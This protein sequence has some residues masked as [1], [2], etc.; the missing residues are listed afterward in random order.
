MGI[1]I[2]DATPID[3]LQDQLLFAVGNTVG[4]TDGCVSLGDVKDYIEDDLAEVAF[5]G[6]YLNLSDT[7]NL[8]AYVLMTTLNTN[9]YNKNQI[10]QLI[11]GITGPK[12]VKVETLPETGETNV[13]YLIKHVSSGGGDLIWHEDLND[14]IG[15]NEED[16]YDEYVWL[17][18]GRTFERIGSTQAN[19]DN[20]YTKSEVNLLIPTVGNGTITVTQGGVSKGTFTVNQSGN[21]TIALDAGGGTQV[22]SD[23]AMKDPKDPSFILN[24]PTIPY[25]S[26]VQITL[27]QGGVTKGSFTLNQGNA[28]TINL[29]SVSQVQSNWLEDDPS[30]PSYIENKPSIP[31]VNNPTITFNQG[32][33]TKGTIT[34]NQ[35]SGTTIN[36][37]AGGGTQVQSDWNQDDDTEEDY[38]K[39]KPGT[40][41][42]LFTYEDDSTEIIEFY[43]KG[44]ESSDNS[45]TCIENTYNGVN[46]VTFTTRTYQTYTPGEY[47]E[48]VEYSKDGENWSTIN[49]TPGTT[50]TVSLNAGEK[51]Y[52]R[53]DSGYF[54][55]S[56]AGGFYATTITANHEH[57]VSGNIMSLLDYTDLDNVPLQK[58][59]F[60]NLFDGDGT[61]TD[62]S[63]LSLPRM[64]LQPKCYAGM[65]QGTYSMTTTPVL[66]ALTMAERCYGSMFSGCLGLTT[67]PSLPATTLA[68]DCYSL[69]FAHCDNLV[70]PPALQATTLAEGCYY[71]MFRGC[72][73]LVQAPELPADYLTQ[74]CYCGMFDSCVSLTSIRVYA[75]YN[76]ASDC[77]TDWL[78]D[79]APTGTF[80]NLGSATYTSSSVSGIPSGWTEART[81]S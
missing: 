32:G 73:R 54:N 49:F 37:D 24:K 71:Q 74:Y 48:S 30:E 44:Q 43:V 55:F 80:Y 52:L 3:E 51:M 40:R 20:Y 14:P 2:K 42:L 72:G 27:T 61:L 23:W 8:E 38:I 12:F 78:K 69:M 19:F 28:T 4:D 35:S 34:L 59:C 56:D 17:P 47:A 13:I 41:R 64:T 58:G 70:N 81:I 6:S 33:I 65:F 77:T 7:P 10:N 60:Y 57:T 16:I 50:Q 66:P 76:S 26:D 29:D 1:R 45:M 79:V 36:F 25:V 22:Q 31:T 15:D 68:T 63:S 18:D 67:A 9:Y 11:G 62:S 53:N 75:D 46:T 39:N 5:T 21:T